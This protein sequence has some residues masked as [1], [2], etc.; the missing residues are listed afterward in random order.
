MD[1]V[2]ITGVC[3]VCWL[4]L[5]LLVGLVGI[6]ISVGCCL[7]FVALSLVG[8]LLP[9]CLRLTAAVLIVL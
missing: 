8:I 7:R 6:V 2:A 5:G 9:G 4:V 3:V 1:S